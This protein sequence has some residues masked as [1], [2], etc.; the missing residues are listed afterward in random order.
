MKKSQGKVLTV[1]IAVISLIAMLVGCSKEGI[2]TDTS[3]TPPPATQKA[4]NVS[5]SWKLYKDTPV[6][7]KFFINHASVISTESAVYQQLVKDTGV[8]VTF[9]SAGTN[10]NEKLNI[11]LATNDLPDMIWT[12]H[13]PQMVDAQKEGRLWSIS[14]LSTKFAPDIVKNMNDNQKLWYK[15]TFDNK[16]IFGVPGFRYFGK[17]DL[18]NPIVAKNNKGDVL[19]KEIYEEFG[20]PNISTPEALQ[21]L[22]RKVKKKYPDMIPIQILF[23]TKSSWDIPNSIMGYESQFGIFGLSD[24]EKLEHPNFLKMLKF[25]NTNYNEG[26]MSTT[27]F[28]DDDAARRKNID[29]GKVFYKASD[30]AIRI[31][32]H[33]IGLKTNKISNMTFTGVEPFVL[34]G[35]KYVSDTL[36]GGITN[37]YTAISK[38]IKYPERAIALLDY[39]QSDRAQIINMFGPNEEYWKMESDGYG[40][41]TQ[42]GQDKYKEMGSSA[43]EKMYGTGAFQF[44]RNNAHSYYLQ[45]EVNGW[46][47]L[48]KQINESNA[49]TNKYYQDFFKSISLTLPIDSNSE[50]AKIFVAL[51]DYISRE[52]IKMV[53]DKPEK[54]DASYKAMMERAKSLGY[55]KYKAYIQTLEKQ[56]Q[57]KIDLYS[58]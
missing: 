56:K 11:Y 6:E 26:L 18:N 7:L 51:K 55:D 1:F 23:A 15:M 34:S 29:G 52:V 4:V 33:N 32:D 40:A 43:Y 2:K 5:E 31:I 57:Q 27:D 25:V 47:D 46:N 45:R 14:E 41:W 39:M 24:V 38:S 42:K 36:N 9:E 44:F 53:V 30:N 37:S 35:A 48:G 8:K 20:K 54:L 17:E 21:D 10:A 19:V 58:K 3:T 28:T 50:E 16:E 13:V 12:G 22:L 49:M